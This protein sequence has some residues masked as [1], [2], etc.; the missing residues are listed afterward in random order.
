M[1]T[2]VRTSH[3]GGTRIARCI[4]LLSLPLRAAQH[5]MRPHRR[6]RIHDRGISCAQAART[7]IGLAS[8]LWLFGSYP[9]QQ[10]VSEVAQDKAVELV[11]S[12]G[13][14]VVIGPLMLA[15][16]VLSARPGLRA[17]YGRRLV[18]PVTGLAALL[19]STAA[20][21]F[22]L[23][24]GVV[25][26]AQGLGG[27]PLLG[28]LVSVVG[29][30]FL[31]PFGLAAIVLSVHHCARLSDVSEVLPPL[32]SPV[33]VW[34]LLVLQVLDASPVVAPPAVRLL[35]LFGPPFSVTVLS[36]WELQRLRTRYALGIRQAL[37]RS[38]S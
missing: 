28:V 3:A 5:L 4:R 34:A 14:L 32:L 1:S 27:M 23:L 6:G 25:R 18:G 20:L 22:L 21:V 30:F 16:F 33:L 15:A 2:Y 7:S 35:F 17:V 19:G 9:L 24:G 13:T 37:G 29:M 8:T 26:L 12:A 11:A 10:S 36:A 31:V 38:N